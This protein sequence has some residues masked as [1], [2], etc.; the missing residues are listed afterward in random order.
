MLTYLNLSTPEISIIW[1]YH[2]HV[3]CSSLI[4][5]FFTYKSVCVAE[6]REGKG[7]GKGRQREKNPTLPL[8][9]FFTS[10]LSSFPSPTSLHFLTPPFL[11]LSS[12]LLLFLFL[13]H[14]H[15]VFS[16]NLEVREGQTLHVNMLPNP[17]HLEA[18]SPVS[19]GKTRARQLSQ[20]A[21]PYSSGPYSSHF[22]SSDNKP[23]FESKVHK[24]RN[25]TQHLSFIYWNC[26]SILPNLHSGPE[27]PGA[28]RY[29]ISWPG[30]FSRV[31]HSLLPPSL[32]RGWHSAPCGEQPDW[33]HHWVGPCKVGLH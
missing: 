2:A 17:S 15:I 25:I 12:P 7:R 1:S 6:K 13:T 31:L 8:L 22:S 9:F 19:M 11:F 30:S 4:L 5:P 3:S 24:R 18:V 14:V 28:W 26:F 16:V 32:W 10:L 23:E 29:V 20:R 33:V 27:S 21:G